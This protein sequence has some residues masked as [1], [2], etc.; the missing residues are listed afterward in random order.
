MAMGAMVG[1]AAAS[2]NDQTTVVVEQPAQ[3]Q[4]QQVQQPI[5]YPIG[6]QLGMLPAGAQGQNIDGAIYYTSQGAWYRPYFGANGVY[7]EVV[8]PPQVKRQ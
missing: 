2:D 1:A 8:A 4:Q 3:Q 5:A 6:T 7:Y